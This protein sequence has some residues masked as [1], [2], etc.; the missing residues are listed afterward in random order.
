MGP[1]AVVRSRVCMQRK[2]IE[3]GEEN[4]TGFYLRVITSPRDIC[5][6]YEREIYV[7]LCY[8]TFVARVL[9]KKNEVF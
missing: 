7:R 3:D 1:D 4:I 5:T 2:N 6:R 8:S 9:R